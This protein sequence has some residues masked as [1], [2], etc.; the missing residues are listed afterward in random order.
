MN[1]I[2]RTITCL[3]E[4]IPEK[5]NELYTQGFIV[6]NVVFNEDE[7]V[8]ICAKK[9]LMPIDEESESTKDER[10]VS[11]INDYMERTYSNSNLAKEFQTLSNEEIEKKMGSVKNSPKIPRSPSLINGVMSCKK[12]NLDVTMKW[13]TEQGF[14]VDSYSTNPSDGRIY[15]LVKPILFSQ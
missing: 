8:S 2:P 13:I 14:K 11:P 4:D 6:R 7:S 10:S 12:E 15:L 3:K 5:V 9:V 1:S